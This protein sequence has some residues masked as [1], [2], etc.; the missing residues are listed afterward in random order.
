VKNVNVLAAGVV[1]RRGSAG[2]TYLTSSRG[3]GPYPQRITE[4]LEHWAQAAADRVFLAQRDPDGAWRCLTYAQTLDRVRRL[5]QALLDRQLSQDRSLVILS[6]NSLEHALLAFAA[7]YTGVL[8]APIAP[9]YSL[10]A[11][12]FTTL[13]EIFQ[14]MRPGLVFAADGHAFS[15]ALRSVLPRGVELAV[16]TSM[17]DGLA[18]TGFAA[19]EARPATAAVD[20]AHARVNG[21][22]VAKI[23]FTSG[24]TGHPKG[25]VN[26]QRMLC[27]NQE[28]I[29]TV[30]P[31]LADEPPVLCDWLPWN[32]TAGG[33]HNIGLVLY[34]GGTF[35]IDDGRP[36]PAGVDAM[37]RNLREVA[38]TAHFT[39]PRTYEALMPYLRADAALRERFFSKLKIFF[40]AA[41]ALSQR[42]F[43]DLQALAVQT[44]GEP[45]LW[46]TGL[47]ATETAPFALCTG[48]TG[49]WSGFVGYPVPGMELKITPVGD[50]LEARVR[51]PNITPGYFKDD[52]RTRAAFDEE[53]FYRM[54]DALR[55]VDPAHPEHGLLFDGR[56]A[57]D[58]KLSSGSWV[59]VGPLRTRVLQQAG[60]Y[61]QDVVLTAPDRE[62][63]GALVFPNTA[64]CRALCPD[65]AADAPIDAVLSDTR[66]QDT[67]RGLFGRL[68]AESTGSSTFVARAL[69]LCDPPSID[70]REITDK[71]SINQKAVLANRAALVEELYA[72]SP[73]A[74]VF[75]CERT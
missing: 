61:V 4:R 66:V 75:V 53:G 30:M 20:D 21:E 33:N 9:A 3:L 10:Q 42:F 49:A 57:E 12:D 72:D 58:F 40:Y 7:M 25:V 62:F 51:G 29:R 38:A 6:G 52:A 55:F 27:S 2:A 43:D 8:Y 36:T 32:H 11:R 41:A 28:M 14:R 22:T 15:R 17:P 37:V 39:V 65:L 26:T 64:A 67:F 16:S 56:L 23:L 60:A 71:G 46:V 70:A 63:V 34:N 5:A 31:F 24:S 35:Y 13:E 59:S 18:A 68:A 48:R 19:L 74:R 73:S 1:A 50:K 44:T 54:G 47:G 45:L 69:L